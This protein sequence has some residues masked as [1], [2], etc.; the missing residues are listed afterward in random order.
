MATI[1]WCATDHVLRCVGLDRWIGPNHK[2]TR[3]VPIPNSFTHLQQLYNCI[4]RSL[5]FSLCT[6]GVVGKMLAKPSP[7][8]VRSLSLSLALRILPSNSTTVIIDTENLGDGATDSTK[9]GPGGSAACFLFCS[10]LFR[11]LISSKNLPKAAQIHAEQPRL[12]SI[13]F[14]PPTPNEGQ[15][16]SLR[17][18]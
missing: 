8:Y 10:K 6:A 15:Q 1:T 4:F 13:R 11:V 9:P 5:F 2:S 7:S 12:S 18:G 14:R 17:S 16:Y 3:D